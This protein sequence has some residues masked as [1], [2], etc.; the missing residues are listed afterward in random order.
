MKIPSIPG[1]AFLQDDDSHWYFCPAGKVDE[2]EAHLEA[3][4]EFW[5]NPPDDLDAYPPDDPDWLNAVGGCPSTVKPTDP[6][7]LSIQSKYAK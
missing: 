4:G 2:A 5:Q 7:V 3:V 6:A 1:I